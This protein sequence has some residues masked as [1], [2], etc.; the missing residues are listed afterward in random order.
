MSSYIWLETKIG[1]RKTSKGATWVTLASSE[2]LRTLLCDCGQIVDLTYNWTNTAATQN[3]SEGPT[4]FSDQR[5]LIQPTTL[6]KLHDR[7]LL[8]KPRFLVPVIEPETSDPED[9]LSTKN[10]AHSLIHSDQSTNHTPVKFWCLFLY[11]PTLS[12]SITTVIWS[13]NSGNEIPIWLGC[14][15]Q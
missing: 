12:W 3:I 4:S 2:Q 15:M 1:R 5:K 6:L 10:K 7:C 11:W 13:C 8:L 14:H 9:G